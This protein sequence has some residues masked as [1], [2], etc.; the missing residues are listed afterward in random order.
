MSGT[1]C[2]QLALPR[3]EVEENDEQRRRWFLQSW[4]CCFLAVW[5][6]DKLPSPRPHALRRPGFCEPGL[7][8]LLL[9]PHSQRDLPSQGGDV[10][11]SSSPFFSD[12]DGKQCF[13]RCG[14]STAA[15]E[16]SGS[17]G[18]HTFFGPNLWKMIP[19]RKKAPCSGLPGTFETAPSCECDQA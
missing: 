16:T 8:C 6:G 3:G 14:W 5:F 4:F 2:P 18:S 13:P 12:C 19:G 7:L 17:M 11:A 9:L 15:R 10:L 1:L